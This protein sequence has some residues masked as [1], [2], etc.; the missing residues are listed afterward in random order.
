MNHTLSN[1]VFSRDAPGAIAS[2]HEGSKNVATWLA[3]NVIPFYL[4]S[5]PAWQIMHCF[6]YTGR[7]REWVHHASSALCSLKWKWPLAEFSVTRRSRC[8]SFIL[9]KK[10]GNGHLKVKWICSV[11][12][13]FWFD[14]NPETYCDETSATEMF[15]QMC[16]K[17]L[18]PPGVSLYIFRL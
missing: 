2:F 15:T 6:P 3:A 1:A 14:L 5:F 9:Q 11:T 8:F 4:F 12:F 10:N 17:V 16:M 18:A 7:H 13:L